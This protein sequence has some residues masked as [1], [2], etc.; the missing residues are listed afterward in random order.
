MSEDGEF[1]PISESPQFELDVEAPEFWGTPR[2][3]PLC[4]IALGGNAI[5][6]ADSEGTFEEQMSAVGRTAEGIVDVMQAGYKVVLTHG[7]GPQVGSLL[8][9]QEQGEPP[10]QPLEVCGAMTQGQIG[11]MLTQQMYQA[12]ERKWKHVPVAS[13]V[14]QTIIDPEDPALEEP[15]K[16]IGPFVD[17]ER[18]E[19]MRAEGMQVK[20]V[21][22]TGNRDYRRVVPSPEPK[23]IVEEVPVKRLID[24]RDLVIC[25]GGGGVPVTRGRGE[26]S[27]HDAVIDKDRLTQVIG[28]RLDADYLLVLTDVDGV[29]V[30]FGTED[31]RRLDTVDADEL[32]EYYDDGQFPEGSMGPKVEAALRFVEG[33]S[34][35]DRTAIITSLDKAVAALEDGEGTHVVEPT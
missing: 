7:N 28:H 26:I 31:E 34:R 29:Y 6:P 16:P 21:R 3:K 4:M 35:R 23:G 11:Y 2:E 24:Q 18:A 33:E 22:D 13:I 14:T 5:D 15:T 30:D 32:R 25:G 9:Q 20:K 10:A 12:L 19:E 8:L 1:K 17:A 27:G